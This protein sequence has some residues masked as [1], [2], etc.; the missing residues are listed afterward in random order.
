MALPRFF[1]TAGI[2][3]LAACGPGSSE[4]GSIECDE[5]RPRLV[6]TPEGD[7]CLGPKPESPPTLEDCRAAGGRPNGVP[8]LYLSCSLPTTDAGKPC[9]GSEG[10]E[11]VCV[12]PEGTEEGVKVTCSCSSETLPSCLQ[13]VERGIA[14]SE[15]CT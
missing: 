9:W 6:R 5:A 1:A 12:A 10:C 14:D 3:F 4:G 7:E 13:P 15:V 11:G 2:C 8:G